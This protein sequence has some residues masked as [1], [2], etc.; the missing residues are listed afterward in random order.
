[1]PL[2]VATNIGLSDPN[3]DPS[4][5]DGAEEEFNNMDEQQEG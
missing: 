3:A 1:V 4:L 5:L 2:E